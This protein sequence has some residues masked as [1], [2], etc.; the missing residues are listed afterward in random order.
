MSSQYKERKF[1]EYEVD[2]MITERLME[3]AEAIG[4]SYSK[5]TG[6]TWGTIDKERMPL[7]IR[8]V[9]DGYA[10]QSK[11]EAARLTALY[12]H[13]GLEYLGQAPLVKPKGKK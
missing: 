3:F 12:D 5:F 11:K 2:K 8:I 7:E 6:S 1:S 4:L 13:F 9:S 10:S